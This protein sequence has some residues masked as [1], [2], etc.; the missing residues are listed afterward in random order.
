MA[1]L[2]ICESPS[3]QKKKRSDLHRAIAPRF[4]CFDFSCPM[5]AAE[6]L[7]IFD[8]KQGG[9]KGTKEDEN[10]TYAYLRGDTG[11]CLVNRKRG[12]RKENGDCALV[13][14]WETFWDL[15]W[16]VEFLIR[17]RGENASSE[18]QSLWRL[19]DGRIF[20]RWLP[21]LRWIYGKYIQKRPWIWIFIAA[22]L[23]LLLVFC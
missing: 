1:A 23:V 16:L 9:R 2:W 20:K 10:G 5:A 17:L 14:V 11:H 6:W 21:S 19:L 22:P 4:K 18:I 12:W 8:I 15:G 3:S 7:S 13:L